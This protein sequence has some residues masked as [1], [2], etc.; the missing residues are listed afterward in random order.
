MKARRF[1]AS[2]LVLLAGSGLLAAWPATA[3]ASVVNSNSNCIYNQ[4]T[5]TLICH[6]SFTGYGATAAAAEANAATHDPGCGA[7]RITV[8]PEKLSDGQWY[9]AYAETCIFG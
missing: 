1:V 5:Q 2:A 8:G 7:A 6:Y 9:V 4:N 3:S